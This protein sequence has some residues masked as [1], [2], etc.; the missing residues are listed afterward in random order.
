[1]KIYSEGRKKLR[2]TEPGER[3]AKGA[4]SLAHRPALQGVL[5]ERIY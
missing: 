1:M 4:E 2:C 3:G 5:P